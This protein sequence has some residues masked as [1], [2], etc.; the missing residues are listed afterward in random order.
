MCVC[1]RAYAGCTLIVVHTSVVLHPAPHTHSLTYFAGQGQQA[2]GAGTGSVSLPRTD[3]SQP[4]VRGAQLVSP[5]FVLFR[6]PVGGA[7]RAALLL[8]RCMQ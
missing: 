5:V 7:F 6:L 1:A 2:A 3:R 8:T 4:S